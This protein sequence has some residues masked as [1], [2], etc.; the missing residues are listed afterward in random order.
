DHGLAIY[1]LYFH[2]DTVA[3]TDGELVDRGQIVGTVGSTGRATGPHLHF[4]VLVG[5]ARVD[6]S[7]LLKLDVGDW[8]PTSASSPSHVPCHAPWRGASRTRGAWFHRA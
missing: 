7:A 3:V 1:T 2:L 6:P 5:G 4:G 8:G